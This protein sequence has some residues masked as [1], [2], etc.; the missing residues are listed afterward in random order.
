MVSSR[1][2][3]RVLPDM[4]ESLAPD[5]AIAEN[6]HRNVV[7]KLYATGLS[8]ELIAVAIDLPMG[9]VRT[10][11]RSLKAQPPAPVLDEQL[12][13]GVRDLASACLRKARLMLEFGSPET[14]LA[15]IKPMLSGLSRHVAQS[16][17]GEGEEARSAF[18]SLLDR[19]RDVPHVEQVV[20]DTDI[21]DVEVDDSNGAATSAPSFPTDD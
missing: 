3:Y 9:R 8:E 15:I 21:V 14:K 2:P 10:I 5:I 19:M 20:T 1:D 4:D 18:E 16:V 12:A 17:G 11:I 6:V 7:S 13:E